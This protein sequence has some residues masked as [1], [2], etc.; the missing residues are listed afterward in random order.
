[1]NIDIVTE[2]RVR[3]IVREEIAASTFA[4]SIAKPVEAREMVPIDWSLYANLGL[5]HSLQILKRPDGS[6]ETVYGSKAAIEALDE[7]IKRLERVLEEAKSMVA[8]WKPGTLKGEY[9]ICSETLLD[10]F[11]ALNDAVIAAKEKR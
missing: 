10:R 11:V 2:A 3:E 4:P 7:R 1:M 5:R 6:S 8:V 9:T